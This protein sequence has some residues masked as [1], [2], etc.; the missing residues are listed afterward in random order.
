[1]HGLALLRQ[2][3][4]LGI[5]RMKEVSFDAEPAMKRESALHSVRTSPGTECAW[6]R[7]KAVVV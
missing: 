3:Y 6:M 4:Y 7:R 5:M 2:L 1:M